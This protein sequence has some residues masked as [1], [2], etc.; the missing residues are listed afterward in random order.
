MQ[1]PIAAKRLKG[2]EDFEE[3]KKEAKVLSQI[4]HV[5][6]VLFLGLYVDNDSNEYIVTEYCDNGSVLDSIRKR[7]YTVSELLTMGLE[8]AKGMDFL[9]GK[10]IIH[11]DL[12]CRNLL[13]DKSNRVKIADF[14]LSRLLESSYYTSATAKFPLR[15]AAK[16]VIQFKKFSIKSDVWSFGVVLWELM[17]RGQLPYPGMNNEAVVDAILNQK[18]RMG[19][20]VGCPE[21]LY[22]LMLKC[23]SETSADRPSFDACGSILTDIIDS[24]PAEGLEDQ[25]RDY[26]TDLVARSSE[27]PYQSP[28]THN[29]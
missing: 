4:R 14:G 5:H 24:L 20:P 12:S 21:K 22:T 13:L 10:N 23:W 1:T 19:A 17:T 8:C 11:R 28:V 7:N 6:V 3:F 15:W 16:E 26:P 25:K 29:N 9:E 27:N 2:K 18:Y